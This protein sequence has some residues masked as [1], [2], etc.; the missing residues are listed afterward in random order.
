MEVLSE[1]GAPPEQRSGGFRLQITGLRKRYGNT[2]AL[3]GLD[4][5]ARAG[6]VLGIAGPNGAGKSTLVRVL[7]GEDVED[8]GHVELAGAG[9]GVEARRRDVSV[10]HQEPKLF[11]TLTV[12]ENLM[13]G[14][15]RTKALRPRP[16]GREAA[17]AKEF[18]LTASWHTP[19]EQCTLVTQQMVEIGR[20]ILHDAKTFLFDEPNSALTVEESEHLFSHIRRLRN[21][22][23]CVVA[24][25]THRLNDLVD[26]CD[27]VVVVRDGRVSAEFVGDSLTTANLGKAIAGSSTPATAQPVVTADGSA[28]SAQQR[29]PVRRPLLKASGWTDRDGAFK[30][31]DLR[32]HEGEALVITGQEGAGGREF[33]QSLAGLRRAQGSLTVEDYATGGKRRRPLAYVPADRATALFQNLSVGANLAA[34]LGRG[35]IAHRGGYLWVGRIFNHG[36]QMV[37]R[38]RIR[39]ASPRVAIGSLSG[40][41]QQKV[42]VGSALAGGPRVLLI[43]EPTRGVDVATKEDIYSALREYVGGGNAVLSFSPELDVVFRLADTVRVMLDGRL[44]EPLEIASIRGLDELAAWVDHV[45]TASRSARPPAASPQPSTRQEAE[46]R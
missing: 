28:T 18:G 23:N 46:Q 21:E 40:G 19:L 5:Q 6:E 20:A 15:E 27:R 42:S 7:A 24:L 38:L 10:V 39:T 45:S 26:E 29:D 1:R 32:V 22:G 33:V 25:V 37:D 30:P 41:N 8:A 34:R 35:S 31:T 44:S 14:V 9:W 2:R 3:D 13:V 36:Q 16:S 4:L 12:A 43:E 11:P 17:I